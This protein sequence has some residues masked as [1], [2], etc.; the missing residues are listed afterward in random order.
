MWLNR[1]FLKA[2]FIFECIEA[3]TDAKT[4][5]VHS[6][7]LRFINALFQSN[8]L[9]I[10]HIDEPFLSP[11]VPALLRVLDAAPTIDNEHFRLIIGLLDLL[12]TWIFNYRM[13]ALDPRNFP[14]GFGFQHDERF[15][16][17]TI[18]HQHL[19]GTKILNDPT[20][21]N[22]LMK[23]DPGSLLSG[24]KFWCVAGLLSRFVEL[25]NPEDRP[26]YF[27]KILPMVSP[28]SY[29]NSSHPKSHSNGSSWITT[30]PGPRL[31]SVAHYNFFSTLPTSISSSIPFPELIS[32]PFSIPV[33][34]I[35]MVVGAM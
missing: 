29:P 34:N 16:L 1:G 32:L 17:K 14:R 19:L 15:R 35:L 12:R 30:S 13:E 8:V 26:I 22:T 33:L 23:C 25:L 24:A 18:Q 2:P 27:N 6:M 7:S 21:L 3:C 28:K 10:R 9:W 11:L 5:F 20:I 31:L 4:V